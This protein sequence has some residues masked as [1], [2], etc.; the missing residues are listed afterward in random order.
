MNIVS[1][2]RD[3]IRDENSKA[4]QRSLESKE[5]EIFHSSAYYIFIFVQIIK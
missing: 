2:F 4:I 5:R 1:G 3:K